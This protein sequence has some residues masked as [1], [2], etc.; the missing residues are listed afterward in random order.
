MLTYIKSLSKRYKLI[1]FVICL[2]FLFLF[3]N[4]FFQ[5][6]VD[7]SI[8][9]ISPYNPQNVSRLDPVL[10]FIRNGEFS[11][12][13]KISTI[14]KSFFNGNYYSDKPIGLSILIL[15]FIYIINFIF[16]SQNTEFVYLASYAF[17]SLILA[18]TFFLISAYILF[19]TCKKIFVRNISCLY[20]TF[21]YAFCSLSYLWTHTLLSHSITSALLLILTCKTFSFVFDKKYLKIKSFYLSLFTIGIISGLAFS[22]EIQSIVASIFI[23]FITFLSTF[24]VGRNLISFKNICIYIFLILG[25]FIIAFLPSMIYYISIYG[26]PFYIA[27]KDVV[28][29]EGMQKGL[30]GISM[31][32]FDVLRRLLFGKARGLFIFSPLTILYPIGILSFLVQKK[33][34]L[35]KRLHIG[36]I[37]IFVCFLYTYINSSYF[38][39]NGGYSTGPR[40][41]VPITGITSLV[42]GSLFEFDYLNFSKKFKT[43]IEFFLIYF[44]G[45]SNVYLLLLLSADTFTPD[46]YQ[47]PLT[48]YLL[49]IALDLSAISIFNIFIGLLSS[50]IIMFI[51]YENL[52]IKNKFF[53]QKD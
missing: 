26:K 40:H 9:F 30:F 16:Q 25:G 31:I 27:Y 42:L 38:Y 21:S 35:H 4:L 37:I 17:L 53:I 12:S 52:N 24:F 18:P 29:F 49:P 46:N 5:A 14:D 15:P 22:I 10:N 51:L 8:N 28:G 39:W 20:A 13:G 43:F 48:E 44:L 7:Q 41:L 2:Y 47:N 34:S 36:L 45:L 19:Q 33:I 6:F 1:F 11:L 32:D 3:V 23:L 50:S